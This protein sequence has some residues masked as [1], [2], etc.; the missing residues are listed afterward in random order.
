MKFSKT[1]I[2]GEQK[3]NEKER[4]PTFLAT[5]ELTDNTYE[6]KE[7]MTTIKEHYPIHV[8]NAILHLSKLLLAEFVTFLGKYLV[9]DSFRLVY[10]GKN[11]KFYN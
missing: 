10:T 11:N 7:L 8:G 3:K 4:K 9:E 6:V 5:T 2:C 1:I